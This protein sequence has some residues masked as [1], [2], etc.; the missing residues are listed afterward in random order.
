[1][2]PCMSCSSPGCS[3]LR[4]LEMITGGQRVASVPGEDTLGS[5]MARA[6]GPHG[7]QSSN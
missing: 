6:E 5:H 7:L 3:N 4:G 2:S 1:M